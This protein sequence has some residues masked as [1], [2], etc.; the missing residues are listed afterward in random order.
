MKICFIP[1]V[2]R[3]ET[4]FSVPEEF[5]KKNWGEKEIS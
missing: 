5:E 2:V 1:L 3:A 4:G